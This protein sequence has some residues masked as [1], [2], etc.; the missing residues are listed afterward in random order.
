M[1]YGIVKSSSSSKLKTNLFTEGDN[2]ISYLRI[3]VSQNELDVTSSS[4]GIK[5]SRSE[6]SI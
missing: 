5:L 4:H 6:L 3:V 1:I 2:S